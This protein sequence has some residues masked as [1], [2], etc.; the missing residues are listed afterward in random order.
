TEDDENIIE[1][2]EK[3]TKWT[4]YDVPFTQTYCY[5][6]QTVLL[7]IPIRAILPNLQKFNAQLSSQIEV[8]SSP[9]SNSKKRQNAILAL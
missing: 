6:L 4:G 9:G 7:I 1:L 8:L 5:V 3:L 2:F